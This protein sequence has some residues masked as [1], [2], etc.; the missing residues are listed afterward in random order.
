MLSCPCPEVPSSASQAPAWHRRT[1]TTARP[2]ESSSCKHLGHLHHPAGC[3]K[4]A[5]KHNQVNLYYHL[6]PALARSLSL[7]PYLCL[8]LSLSPPL[9]RSLSLSASITLS[10][11]PSTLSPAVRCEWCS[12][13]EQG[14]GSRGKDDITNICVNCFRCVC[15]RK[16]R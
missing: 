14:Q 7:S 8:S 12:F 6:Y 9:S 5:A 2:R 11:L 15:K 16:A 1:Q 3:T 10:T 13:S 4:S